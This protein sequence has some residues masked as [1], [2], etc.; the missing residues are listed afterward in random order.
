MK[1]LKLRFKNLNSLYG[2]WCI[3]FTAPEYIAN[4]IF[5]ITGPTG[6]GKSTILDALCLALYGATPRL[7]KISKSSNE[8]M[9]RQTGECFAEVTFTAAAGQFICHW[10]QHRAHKK[11]AGNL[12]ETRHEIA[13]SVSGTILE[14]KKRNVATVIEQKTGM[15]FERFTRSILLAQ[16]GFDTFLKAD[17]DHRAPIL[18]Q[19]TGSEIYTEISK[20]VHERQRDEREKLN[21]LLT[22]TAGIAILTDE[23]E[24][25]ITA[26][27]EE[28]HNSEHRLA[29][30]LAR[31]DT[32]VLWHNEI[33]KLRREIT[34]LTR[35]NETQA[36]INTA[37]EPKRE[38]LAQARKAAEL[39][40]EFATLSTLRRQHKADQDQLEIIT[41]ELPE[42]ERFLAIQENLLQNAASAT[43]KSKS[44]QR[45]IGQIIQRVRL[46]DQ[47]LSDRKSAI[48]VE[49]K[50]YRKLTAQINEQQKKLEQLQEGLKGIHQEIELARKYQSANLRD[51]NLITQLAGIS[52][53]INNLQEIIINLAAKEKTLQATEK[54]LSA[55]TELVNSQKLALD[56]WQR[57]NRSSLK[58][59]QQRK[60]ELQKLLKN[61][62][63]REY[64]NEKEALLKEMLFI[65]KIS[66]LEAERKLLTDD[67]PCPL[68]GATTHPFAEA[69][70]PEISSAEKK[71]AAI[72]QTIDQAEHLEN[73]I[74]QL[75]KAEK[76][77]AS[78]LNR[79]EKSLAELLNEKKNCE[80]SNHRINTELN[81][82][83]L[84]LK[85][86]QAVLLS[87]L[88]PLAIDEIPADNLDWLQDS[89]QK[90]H[91][92]WLEMLDKK[93]SVAKQS[94]DLNRASEKVTA[95]ITTL[96]HSAN[97]KKT[98]L[99]KNRKEYDNLLSERRRLFGS[100]N[101]ESEESRLERAVAK[102][103]AD[104]KTARKQREQ[105]Q[106]TLTAAK[107]QITYLQKRVRER[108]KELHGR[109]AEFITHLQETGFVDEAEFLTCRLPAAERN[110]LELRARELDNLRNEL[111]TR[112][113][114]HENRLHEE[115]AKKVTAAELSELLPQQEKLSVSLKEIHDEI[116]GRKQRLAD[117]H[118]AR[119]KIKEKQVLIAARKREC[120]KWEKLHRLI[121][122][123]DG[124][125]FRNFAQGLTFELMVAHAN[126]QLEKMT[127][128]YLL[129]RDE[130]EPLELNVVD[131]YQAG[132]IRST[133]NLSGGE[134]FIVS[135]AL[136]LGLAKM[137]SRKVRVDSLFLDEGFGT[138]D[139]EALETA[140]ETL[141]NLQQHGKLI[142]IISHVPALKERISTQINILPGPGGKSRITGPGC[143]KLNQPE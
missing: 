94:N 142:G 127:D 132:E 36:R 135:L 53:Q 138:L 12:I 39:E 62:L 69:N 128:R 87:R 22:E 26:E 91:D 105:A 113:K 126:Q 102:A 29:S 93:E 66:E 110:Q 96:N 58:L 79:I 72:T 89:L 6:A 44:E 9:S 41:I 13:D 141:A 118:R 139:E 33:N 42:K 137:A 43:N 84:H 28:K 74:S 61:R 123:A 86:S 1:I 70:I 131:N 134:S 119:I 54:Q 20:R 60:A 67:K 115:L 59:I 116:G 10:Q 112:K 114:D 65:H 108:D 88:K 19:I 2:E 38:K 48:E 77:S 51:E 27:L 120:H 31:T 117:N 143:R 80:K 133:K 17:S 11:A 4:G 99:V 130:K 5:A 73:A 76:E 95:I 101:P 83:N 122:S 47:Q 7:G 92:K 90:R 15:N 56:K 124:K 71:I 129:L 103:E 68:C 14:S 140:L 125:K 75:E 98:T 37:F 23:Q 121:G 111:K 24:A 85:Q 25:A 35:E 100:K 52:E 46:L 21:L 55:T 78:K 34:I 82:L 63:L 30:E 45:T 50:E 3:D 40:G 104:E 97:D 136:A 49:E 64:R 16:G 57:K 32:A 8:I 109:T 81:Q 106:Q 18:E 107:V